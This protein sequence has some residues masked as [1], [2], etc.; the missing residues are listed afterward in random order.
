MYFGTKNVITLMKFYCSTVCSGLSYSILTHSRTE[1]I[2]FTIYESATNMYII[3][4]TIKHE[5]GY[6]LRGNQVVLSQN[7]GAKT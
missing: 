2:V 7:F 5:L 3:W 1:K 4:L 6:H